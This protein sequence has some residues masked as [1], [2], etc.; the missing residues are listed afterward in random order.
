[1]KTLFGLVV[2]T[3]LLGLCFGLPLLLI[4][5][6]LFTDWHWIVRVGLG[7]GAVAFVIEYIRAAR[8]RG[9]LRKIPI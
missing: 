8:R 9:W 3:F 7:I 5:G 2:V 1:M 6:A 4:Y